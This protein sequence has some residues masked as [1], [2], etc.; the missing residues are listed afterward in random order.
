MNSDERNEREEASL[1]LL[2]DDVLEILSHCPDGRESV[3]A[4]LNEIRGTFCR[5]SGSYRWKGI[6][7][8]DRFERMLERAGFAV[9]GGFN[10]RNQPRREV[11][12]ETP[13]ERI[14]RSRRNAVTFAAG[15]KARREALAA[16]IPA[17]VARK[18]A[19]AAEVL[20][21]REFASST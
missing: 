7:T 3:S 5:S 4:L 17:Y 9:I 15:E 16:G 13:S 10:T 8:L 2:A 11:C 21:R 19:H 14:A 6:G 12:V 20:A 18:L 1:K